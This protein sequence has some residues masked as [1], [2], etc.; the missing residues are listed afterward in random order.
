MRQTLISMRTDKAQLVLLKEIAQHLCKE[1]SPPSRKPIK[2]PAARLLVWV[3]PFFQC[4]CGLHHLVLEKE[5]TTKQIEI[6]FLCN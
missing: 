2:K 3:R 1:I 4:S 5:I 6:I